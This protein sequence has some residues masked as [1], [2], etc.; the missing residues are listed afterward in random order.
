MA[1]IYVTYLTTE[2]EYHARCSKCGKL[3]STAPKIRDL[4]LNFGKCPECEVELKNPLD[5]KW[6]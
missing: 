5:K 1:V 3:L 6:G 4:N 2:Y